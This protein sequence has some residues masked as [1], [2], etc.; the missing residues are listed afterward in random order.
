MLYSE[1]V[2]L[3]TWKC[4]VSAQPTS[5]AQAVALSS[6]CIKCS[7]SYMPTITHSVHVVTLCMHLLIIYLFIH[8]LQSHATS[9]VMMSM[10]LSRA[11]HYHCMTSGHTSNECQSTSIHISSHAHRVCGV[12]AVSLFGT[13][14]CHR[15]ESEDCKPQQA[16]RAGQLTGGK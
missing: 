5:F 9:C 3:A 14:M 12:L 2:A 1:T 11:T 6:S 10:H 13:C 7:G 15:I 16:M 4:T 8:F